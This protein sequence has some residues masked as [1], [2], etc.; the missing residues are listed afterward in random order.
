M[1]FKT[2]SYFSKS[3]NLKHKQM[4]QNHAFKK[5]TKLVNK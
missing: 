3:I 4:K 2:F 1:Y 5:F